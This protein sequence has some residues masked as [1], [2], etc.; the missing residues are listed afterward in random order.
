MNSITNFDAAPAEPHDLDH[1]YWLEAMKWIDACAH[2]AELLAARLAGPA[3]E[4]PSHKELAFAL[5]QTSMLAQ[6]LTCIRLYWDSIESSQGEVDGILLEQQSR[7]ERE[8]VRQQVLDALLM[9]DPILREARD[10]LQP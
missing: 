1:P 5:K 7:F 4:K 2:E 10:A 3:L 9:I 8:K 6:L